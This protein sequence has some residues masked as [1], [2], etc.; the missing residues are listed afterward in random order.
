MTHRVWSKILLL[1]FLDNFAELVEKFQL[2]LYRYY[3]SGGQSLYRSKEMQAFC[4]TRAPHL[5]DILISA[6]TRADG[7]ATSESHSNLQQQRTV[8]LL[9][10]LAYFRY[11]IL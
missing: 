2:A 7:R 8:A 5:F 11:L 1:H 3:E 4:E 9:H 6:I 10:T